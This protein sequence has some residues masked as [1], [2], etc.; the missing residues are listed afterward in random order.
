KCFYPT[1]IHLSVKNLQ[2]LLRPDQGISVDC[3]NIAVR[4]Q[5]YREYKTLKQYNSIRKYTMDLRFCVISS[6]KKC[7]LDK[8]AT[9]RELATAIGVCEDIKYN[10]SQCRYFILPWL[11]EQTYMLYVLDHQK[12]TVLMID[13]RPVEGWCTDTP[14]LMYAEQ[15]LGFRLNYKNAMNEYIPG[16]DE[17]IFKWKFNRKINVVDDTDG[18]SSGYLILQYMFVW[19]NP[20][21]KPIC[22]SGVE[23][24]NNLFIDLLAHERNG[25]R[26]FLPA[27]VKHYLSRITERSIN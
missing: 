13:S 26:R 21:G 17:D 23:M 1:T 19:C 18:H 7:D 16:W 10:L 4:F 6:N 24:R 22:K 25:Y 2:E 12:N 8:D 14:A 27:D 3:F 15:T 9:A 20:K 11:H 5:A